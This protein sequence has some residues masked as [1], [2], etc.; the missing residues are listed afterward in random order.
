MNREMENGPSAEDSGFGLRVAVVAPG[1]SFPPW[2]S[3]SVARVT[4]ALVNGLLEAGHRVTLLAAANSKVPCELIPVSD[5][6]IHLACDPGLHLS[7]RA[8]E[9][10][11]EV[12]GD[13]RNRIDIVHAQGLDVGEFRSSRLL[14][15][16]DFPNVTTCHS[17][18]EIAN[19]IYFNQCKSN[20]IAISH[21]QRCACPSARFVATVYN[22]L[23]PDPFPIV[24]EPEDYL[25][26][27]GR[28][29]R[30][31][32]PH[33]A[34]QLAIALQMKLKIAGP[35]DECDPTRYFYHECRQYLRHPL[36]DYL[37]E[38]DMEDKVRLL[39]MARCNLHPT[40]F[41]EPFGLVPV[42]A[43]YCG[44]PT[45]AIRRGALPELVE[46]GRTG[47]LVEDFAEGYFKGPLC[48]ALDRAYIARRTRE[49]FNYRR[50]ASEYVQAYG[51]IIGDA[52]AGRRGAR[53]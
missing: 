36:V 10:T 24:T 32:Q 12:I 18:I 23:D 43:G 44:T 29:D 28:M 42:E 9:R 16:L 5:D 52:R 45:L 27:L 19:L 4:E 35:I 7:R 53:H 48:F 20:L 3:A 11:L 6:S 51:Q 14:E 2:P 30:V 22:G 39:S 38:L 21:S 40:G 49:R 17:C 50:M 1:Q 41:R 8:Q 37:G 15:S 34:M 47:I 26:F 31:K 46:H 13:I 33:L 25:C